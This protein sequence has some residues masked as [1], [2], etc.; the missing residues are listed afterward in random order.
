[1]RY[2]LIFDFGGVI[3]KTVTP[4]PRWAWDDKLG[5]ARGS[6]ER[7]VHNDDSWRRAQTGALSLADYWIDVAGRLRHPAA[8]MPQLEADFYGGDQLDSAIIALIKDRKAAGQRV[9]L[10]SNDS[11]ALIAKLDRLKIRELFDPLVVSAHI[12]V[13][14]PDPAAYHAVLDPLGYAAADT[15]FIDDMPANIEGALAVGMHGIRYTPDLDLAQALA[16][17]FQ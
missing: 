5:L 15:V 7:A 6:T 16:P 8:D 9:A 11:P 1:M 17:F 12:G 2:A 13:M 4:A 14:K 3:M 10:L